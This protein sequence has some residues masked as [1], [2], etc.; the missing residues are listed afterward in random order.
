MRFYLKYDLR[1]PDFG[2]SAEELYQAC[3]EQCARAEQH[4]FTGVRF[5]EHHASEDGYLPSPIVMGG[6]VAGVTAT[7][8]IRFSVIVLPLH[9]PLRIAEDLAVLDIASR[10][11]VELVVGTGYVP[12]EFTMFG[13]DVADR[14]ALVDRNVR[15]LRASWTGEEFDIDGRPVRVRPRPYQGRSIPIALG[16]GSPTGYSTW[17]GSSASTSSSGSPGGLGLASSRCPTWS[18]QQAN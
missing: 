16:T 1:A 5:H 3:I 4:G 12:Y 13:R 18:Y 11:R 7:L 2:P 10:G 8:A 6:A 14:V 15:I 17:A 9:D